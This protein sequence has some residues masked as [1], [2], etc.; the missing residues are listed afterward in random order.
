MT[1]NKKQAFAAFDKFANSRAALIA[2]LQKAGI[3]TVEEARP[4]VVEWVS[5]KTGC[6]YKVKGTGAVVLDS[7]DRRYEGAKTAVRDMM[8]MIQGTTR[9]K[10][11]PQRDKTDPVADLLA[12]YNDL[13]PA[14]KRAFRAAI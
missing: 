14:Q 4:L 9:R 12:K 1:I 2:E 6:A 3:N 5:G 10:A 11:S 8:L 7:S 13:T